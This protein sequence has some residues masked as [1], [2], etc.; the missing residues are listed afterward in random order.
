MENRLR[1]LQ[2]AGILFSRL[3]IRAVTMDYIAGHLG[4]SKRTIYELFSD[5]DDLLQQAIEEGVKYHRDKMISMINEAGNVIEAIVKF[6]QYHHD[7]L[8]KVHPLFLEDLEKYHNAVYRNLMESGALNDGTV[9][10]LILKKGVD[11]G[12]FRN[13]I[14]VNLA[15]IFLHETLKFCSKNENRDIAEFS[16]EEVGRTIFLPYLRGICT[17]E[18]LNKLNNAKFM[19]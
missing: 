2:E 12:T 15:N 4:V 7:V 14:N 9:S 11:D 1:I 8:G 5:K 3:G 10:K 18:G 13:D 17:E 16:K 19:S 6:S